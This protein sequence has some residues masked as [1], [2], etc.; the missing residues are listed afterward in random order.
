MTSS[1]EGSLPFCF[2]GS[3][4]SLAEMCFFA[5]LCSRCHLLNHCR[6][7][8]LRFAGG[9]ASV[10]TPSILARNR[11]NDWDCEHGRKG[12]DLFQLEQAASFKGHVRCGTYSVCRSF[13]R[14]TDRLTQENL[15]ENLSDFRKSLHVQRRAVV[16]WDS[17][18]G[19]GLV[20]FVEQRDYDDPGIEDLFKEEPLRISGTRRARSMSE[21]GAGI[22]TQPRK[23]EHTVTHY[24]FI[25][26]D[27]PSLLKFQHIENL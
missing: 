19:Q 2:S 23:C 24:C 11:V 21:D 10:Q 16:R 4:P 13:P 12:K 18:E 20:S 1:P 6:S 22:R 3:S 14:N 8:R 15:R 17:V 26:M 25:D 9:P 27:H 7:R 5:S